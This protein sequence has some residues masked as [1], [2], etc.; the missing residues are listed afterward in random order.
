MYHYDNFDAA[1]VAARVE[2]FRDQV[3]RRVFRREAEIGECARAIALRK[4]VGLG[5]QLPEPFPALIVFEV[6]KN[7]ELAAAGIDGEPRDRRQI[8]ARYQEHIGAMR[9]KCPAGD[10]ARDYARQIEHTQTGERTVA[11]GPRFGRGV[12]DFLD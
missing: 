10:R 12:T 9:G 7:R 2:Q 5:E 8:R 3:A 11:L 4:D 6:E 1:F